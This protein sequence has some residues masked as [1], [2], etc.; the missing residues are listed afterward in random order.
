M[1][2]QQHFHDVDSACTAWCELS[3]AEVCVGVIHEDL[4]ANIG[5]GCS[6]ANHAE[7]IDQHRCDS[8]STVFMNIRQ[9]SSSKSNSKQSCRVHTDHVNI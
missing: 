1:G 3:A 5:S 2:L 7:L 4:C 9:A 6:L 8:F